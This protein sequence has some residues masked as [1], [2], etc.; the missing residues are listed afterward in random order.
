MGET[1]TATFRLTERPGPG[2]CGEGTGELA[3]TAF[4]IEDGKIAEWRRVGDGTP[5]AEDIFF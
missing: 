2:S 4:E 5:Q 1:V 3:Q